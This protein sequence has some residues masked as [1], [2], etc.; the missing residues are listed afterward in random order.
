MVGRSKAPGPIRLSSSAQMAPAASR[1][2][3]FKARTRRCRTLACVGT[4]QRMA[5]R[6]RLLPRRGI[7]PTD[8]GDIHN[9]NIAD[10]WRALS[11]D[12]SI[13]TWAHDVHVTLSEGLQQYV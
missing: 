5:R 4:W 2:T 9:L 3:F 6:R 13:D 11:V 1:C 8:T 10:S 7:F 12:F